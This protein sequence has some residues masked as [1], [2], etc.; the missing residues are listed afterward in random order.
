MHMHTHTHT[1]HKQLR[2]SRNTPTGSTEGPLSG[3]WEGSRDR[4]T[5]GPRPSTREDHRAGGGPQAHK[6]ATN[7]SFIRIFGSVHVN[8]GADRT[9]GCDR[10]LSTF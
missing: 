7:Y 6:H 9:I 5:G 1:H 8:K 10:G 2:H 4:R 3:T